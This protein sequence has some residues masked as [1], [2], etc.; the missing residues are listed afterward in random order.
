MAGK[1][2]A[3]KRFYLMILVLSLL[4]GSCNND[5]GGASTK[6]CLN[7]NDPSCNVT[8]VCGNDVCEA[9]ETNVSCPADCTLTTC[10]NG[11]CDNGEDSTSCPSDCDPVSVCGNGTCEAGENQL[12]CPAD[13]SGTCGDGV[14]QSD[15][16]VEGCPNDCGT[17]VSGNT[18]LCGVSNLGVCRY[19]SQ[20]C[21][22]GAWGECI[23][24][25]GPDLTEVCDGQD[26]DCDG[27]VDNGPNCP[28]VIGS[29]RLCGSNIGQCNNGIQSCEDDGSGNAIW[30]ATCDGAVG[31]TPEMCNGLDDDCNGVS[32]D[33]I[34]CQCV[35]SEARPCGS[36]VGECSYG[37]QACLPS[38][39]WASV[40]VNAILPST[41]VCDSL[42]ND[43]NGSVDE[44]IG[45]QCTPAS[46]RVCGSNVGECSYGMQTC[47][48]AGIWGVCAD[49]ILPSVE[50]CDGLDNDCNGAVDDGV[51]CQ[52]TN[53]STRV[54]G[55][56]TGECRTGIQSCSAGVWGA[57]NGQVV[58]VNEVCDGLDNDCNGLADEGQN[59]QCEA[60][61]TRPCGSMVG[62]CRPG[63]QSC[64]A[65]GLGGF[66]WDS[67]C[68][69]QV[70]PSAEVC[71]D[72]DND[73]NGAPDDGI[74][75][76][77]TPG[78]TRTC[79]VN[80]GSCEAGNQLCQ[81]DYTW[82]PCA[83]AIWPSTETCN[84]LDDDCNGSVDDNILC[85][86][87]PGSVRT[88]GSAVGTCETGSQ[89]CLASF[90]WGACTGAVGPGTEICN[91]LDDD[92]NGA[93]DDGINCQCVVGSTRQCGSNL[94]TC[95]KGTQTCLLNAGTGETYWSATCSGQTVP[96][97]EVCDG[98]DND[99][100]GAVDDGILCP[101]VVGSTR[102]CGSAIGQ[103]VPGTQSC[104]LVGSF[105]QWGACTDMVLPSAETCNGLDDD[106][107][108][109]PDDSGLCQCNP[110]ETRV[111]GSNVGECSFGTQTCG[112][113][114]IWLPLCAMAIG[115]SAEICDG[116]DNDCNGAVDDGQNC[117]C[118]AGDET[119]CGSAVGSCQQGTRVCLPS[120]VWDTTC[121]GM[122]LPA[123]E[124]CN[125]LDDD[126][127]GS[128]DDGIGCQCIPGSTRMCGTNVGE[129]QQGVQVCNIN[130]L[131][132]G[133]CTG[134]VGPVLEICDGYD[135][136]CNGLTDEGINC[137]C[138]PG[139]TKLCGSNLGECEMGIQSCVSDGFGG[140][141]W[142]GVC[143][144]EAVPSSE[145]CD[146]YDNDCN[147]VS[148]DAIGCQCIPGE[149][150]VCGSNEGICSF[151][152]QTCVGGIWASTCV[153]GTGPVDE[154]CD[155]YDN[156][157]NGSIDDGVVCQCVFGS[158][159]P[160]GSAV[161]ECRQGTQ[162]CLFNIVTGET[163]WS[164]VCSGSVIPVPETCDGRD[165]DCNGAVDENCTCLPGSTRVCGS[166]I[167][168]C[169]FGTQT[170]TAAGVWG[171]TCAGAVIP[172]AELCDAVDNDC[173]G[174]IDEG[175]SCL[176]GSTRPCGSSVGECRQ[177]TQTCSSGVW[178]LCVGSIGPVFDGP[179]TTC[180][181]RDNDCNGIVDDAC[182]CV[183]GTTSRCGS[184]EG[185]CR[186]GTSTCTG[187]FWGVCVGYVGPTAEI[188]GNLR[189]ENC[190]GIADDPGVCPFP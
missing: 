62:Q 140:F 43:C 105:T 36:N 65:D 21:T 3:M 77:C 49:Q 124:T 183:S 70:G 152:T 165:N 139:Q 81:A 121:S 120:G 63:T 95:S 127:N 23:G 88:C 135:N 41:E 96:V 132:W 185:E 60:G 24:A 55:T 80:T 61:D 116:R 6:T 56:A 69:G 112:S 164:P 97:G 160:C 42:D 86:C 28:C 98:L 29:T 74:L 159:R 79:G 100:N 76:S 12:S 172:S 108:G 47:G 125:G 176:N 109:T 133:A 75:C 187:G 25:V 122:V 64:V 126:C 72:R 151:G 91:G 118:N 40:C 2:T 107:N 188:C 57:C 26:N 179:P 157:C 22:E 17:C 161:G 114:G 30:G 78:S 53:G 178:G 31:P 68:V 39:I 38:G 147:G 37:T 143:V 51:G 52:C 189:D 148:D 14:C 186:A 44:G 7:P 85:P 92:C 33:A 13:C 73:C 19:G 174:V 166:S 32:D 115:P 58:A 129:C 175:C 117:Q 1:E 5:K 131:G 167:G 9:G 99:C 168:Q 134:G 163:Y 142:G 71:D 10:G 181:S 113:D 67:N 82:G 149:S 145:V 137:Q 18:R 66:V 171:A 162:D 102:L 155:G 182:G 50:L 106:C 84:N 130:G 104:V 111:C 123:P 103:C 138:Q 90:S 16:T 177:G 156:D 144:G 169:S 184:D 94:G 153:G 11:V 48:V 8:P 34:G 83:G 87:Q 101:C 93:I 154:I 27:L 141:V 119:V 20:T 146:G 158:V 173:N 46:N 35:P 190:N 170:C 54:C 15:E 89:T 45:C 180:D 150:R 128:V 136:D 110:N 59:C 4:A